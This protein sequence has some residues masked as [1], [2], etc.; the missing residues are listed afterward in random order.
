V[1]TLD[2]L[3]AGPGGLAGFVSAVS[4]RLRP[5]SRRDLFVGAAVAGSALA[6][7]P[8]DY[9]LRPQPAYATICGPG[10]TASSGWTV[11]CCTVNKGVNACP[12]GSFAAG[13][14]KAADSSWCGSGYRYIVDCNASC[15]KCSTGC[16][17]GICDSKCWSCS[18]GT[19][20]S[21]TC[22]QRRICCNAFRYGQCNTQVK[23]SG[24]VHCR[25]VSCVA[26]YKWEA[27]T[28]TS[29]QDN[30]TNEHSA[31][32]LPRW[33][34]LQ[35][36]YDALGAQ[37]SFLK[38]S[39][40][41]QRLVGDA[42]KGQYI[43]Y[44]GGYIYWSSTSG[45]RAMTSSVRSLY[46]A[47][48]GPTGHLGYPNSD[49]VRGRPDT[50][51]IHF[52]EKGAMT[53]SASTSAY[54][55]WGIR[56]TVWAKEGREAGRLGYPTASTK[57][58]P[59]GAWIQTFQK[60]AITDSTATSTQSVW[61]IR[62][63]VWVKVGRETGRLGF[64]IAPYQDLGNGAWIQRFQKGAITDS[65]STTTQVVHGPVY[66]SWVAGGREKGALRFPTGVQAAT[67]RGAYQAFQGGEVWVLGSG[68]GRRVLGGVLASWK[69]QGGVSGP[70]GYPISDTTSSNGR[71]TCTF[72]GG[73][74]T[75]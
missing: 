35:Q 21:A 58:L 3:N 11:F 63:T 47:E 45:A 1:S 37:K 42:K 57:D 60:G 27:C 29:L 73:T 67:D 52:F 31:P 66:T 56:Y 16:T 2:D 65:T 14:W 50:G 8:K 72:E 70:Y 53:R 36:K 48:G 24:G 19:G 62:H 15:S 12:P 39:V 22:D 25:V 46:A 34:V 61:G 18:C 10:N 9:V 49:I 23:C 4:Q 51:W 68:P 69:Q 54:T 44:Q 74:I 5:V 33:N 28:T 40:G 6:T 13:W 55:V 17:D 7:R 43:A 38:A 41:P 59:N 64:P 32:C 30:R 71:L 26:P 20:S 75:V